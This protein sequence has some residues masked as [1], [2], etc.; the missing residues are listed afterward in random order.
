MDFRA[1]MDVLEKRKFPSPAGFRIPDC[2]AH[3]LAT[4][5][6]TLYS[7]R[8]VVHSGESSISITSTLRSIPKSGTVVVKVQ[9]ALLQL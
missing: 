7:P 3:S 6:T 8:K 9:L 1:D 4:I 2:P 5:S